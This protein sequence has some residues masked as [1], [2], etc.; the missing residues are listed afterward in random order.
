[1]YLLDRNSVIL[2]Q[3]GVHDLLTVCIQYMTFLP[4]IETVIIQKEKH[5]VLECEASSSNQFS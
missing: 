5:Y 3:E 2:M 4:M 1:M